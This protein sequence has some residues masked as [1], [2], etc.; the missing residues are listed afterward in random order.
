MNSSLYST[1]QWLATTHDDPVDK[2]DSF[3]LSKQS[4]FRSDKNSSVNIK[5]TRYSTTDIQVLRQERDTAVIQNYKLERELQDVRDEIAA[6]QQEYD[7][8]QESHEQQVEHI[9]NEMHPGVENEYETTIEDTDDDEYGREDSLLGPVNHDLVETKDRIGDY[10]LTSLVGKGKFARVYKGTHSPTNQE[11]AIKCIDKSHIQSPKAMHQLVNELTVLTQISHSN[12]VRAVEIHHAPLGVYAVMELGVMDLFD[13]CQL[14]GINDESTLREVM[15]G[16]LRPLEFLHSIGICH[17]DIKQENVLLMMAATG[18]DVTRNHVRLCDFGLCSF[19]TSTDPRDPVLQQG[20]KGTI[21]LVAPQVF[22]NEEYDARPVDMWAVG[23]T[24]LE[25]VH[26]YPPG[27]HHAYDFAVKK[28]NLVA[29]EAEL[30]K[31]LQVL[32]AGSTSIANPNVFDIICSLL[33]MDPSSR[34]TASRV[35]QHPWFDGCF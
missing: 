10:H 15:I 34:R 28:H 24:L 32:R 26:E 17:S 12:M 18:N 25:L 22:S 20:F 8:L 21:P 35:L 5:S 3:V 27:W 14:H 13:Y 1:N 23:C 9:L 33:R 11:Y 19:S 29:F 2:K 31:C 4:T 16:I 7:T 30:S 6:R